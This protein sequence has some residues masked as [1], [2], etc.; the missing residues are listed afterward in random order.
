MG[1]IETTQ[2]MKKEVMFDGVVV[3]GASP[4]WIKG[5]KFVGVEYW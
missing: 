4:S 2:L 3:L 5:A 1:K